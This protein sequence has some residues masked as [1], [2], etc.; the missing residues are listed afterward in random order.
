MSYSAIRAGSSET[1][2]V[3]H[4]NEP[5]EVSVGGAWWGSLRTGSTLILG[6]SIHGKLEHISYT[7]KAQALVWIML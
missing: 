1:F 3:K 6:M 2:G 4:Q 7:P 5:I